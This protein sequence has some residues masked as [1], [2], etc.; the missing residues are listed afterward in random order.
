MSK[1]ITVWGSRG[2][3]KT[4][5]AI[6]SSLALYRRLREEKRVA[7]VLADK[8]APAVS[9]IFPNF[10]KEKLRSVGVPLSK[11][12]IS[13]SDVLKN[14]ITVPG[15]KN[16]AILGYTDGENC[17]SYPEFSEDKIHRF[18][19]VLGEIVDYIII[20][21]VSDPD[22]VFTATALDMCETLF[23]VI[24]PDNKS[25][26]WCAS[27]ASIA[28]EYDIK[29][30]CAV[31][32]NVCQDICLPENSGYRFRADI[33]LII[34]YSPE[35]KVLTN[36]GKLL[37]PTGNRLFDKAIANAA[38][39]ISDDGDA[40]YSDFQDVLEKLDDGRTGHDAGGKAI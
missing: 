5:F 14:M 10:R 32:N 30:K 21:C 4:T 22:D 34:P 28:N 19:E 11:P 2:S 26:S 29:K 12:V 13:R 23:T 8:C 36:S 27:S 18:L 39:I 3:G 17:Y 24:N 33:G 15:K 35:I 7:V 40:Y 16:Y 38:S 31:V 1:I 25:V 6:R 9:Y 20:D 37:N